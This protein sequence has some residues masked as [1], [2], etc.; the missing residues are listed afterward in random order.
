MDYSAVDLYFHDL[1]RD[2]ADN[3]SLTE[4]LDCLALQIQAV[5]M[6]AHRYPGM[7]E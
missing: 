2:I 1:V 7:V 3:R 5:R 4:A 6:I